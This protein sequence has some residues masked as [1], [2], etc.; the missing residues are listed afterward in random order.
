MKIYNYSIEEIS[1]VEK[2]FKNDKYCA[3]PGQL[4]PPR[5]SAV[6]SQPVVCHEMSA[7]EAKCLAYIYSVSPDIQT[8][9]SKLKNE[10][11]AEFSNQL[12]GVW[13]SD[14]IRLS[15]I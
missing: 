5:V 11:I 8:P 14:E 12:R 9:R 2:C 15:S 6:C 4:C 1:K 7:A 3:S 13:I 10:E